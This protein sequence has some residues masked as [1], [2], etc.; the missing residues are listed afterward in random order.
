MTAMSDYLEN[1][2]VNHLFR[3]STFAKPTTI[4]IALCTSAP[5]DASTGATITEVTNANGYARVDVGAPNNTLWA[6]STTN[7][8]TSNS[9]AITFPTA[10]G[11]WNAAVTHVA[12]CDSATYGAGNLLFWGAL[13]SNK[14]VTNG[15]VFQFAAGQL[16]IQ[17]DN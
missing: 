10:S 5:T 7:G 16:S 8:T 1:N 2:L 15:D 4:A 12:I 17:L 13:S 3:T 11:D 9:N 14:T 6:A